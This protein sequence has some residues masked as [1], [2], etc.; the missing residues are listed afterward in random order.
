[1]SPRALDIMTNE[2]FRP[3]PSRPARIPPVRGRAG[4]TFETF[5]D[6]SRETVVFSHGLG[7]NRVIWFQQ[8]PEFARQYHVINWDQRGFG[9]SSAASG[10][11]GPERRPGT[12]PRSSTTFRSTAPTS[13]G[14]RWAVGPRWASL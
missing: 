4:S 2:P 10:K 11:M 13:S 9:R 14:N 6:P 8:V 3:D 1:M 12:S 7:G 5:G